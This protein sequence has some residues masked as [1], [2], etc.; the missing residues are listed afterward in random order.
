MT[1]MTILQEMTRRLNSRNSWLKEGDSSVLARNSMRRPVEPRDGYAV[2]WTLYG[3]FLESAPPED[4]TE[5]EEGLFE[6]KAGTPSERLYLR[7]LEVM[8]AIGYGEDALDAYNDD[9]C[10]THGDIMV[11]LGFVHGLIWAEEHRVEVKDGNK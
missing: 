9:P 6:L 1:E 11:M 8:E 7:F 3:A 10:T 2:A 5:E 4:F